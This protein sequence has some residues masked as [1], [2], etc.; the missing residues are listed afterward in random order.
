MN[1]GSW[2]R[3]GV[4]VAGVILLTAA[5]GAAAS[6]TVTVVESGTGTPL[7]KATVAVVS[8]DTVVATG[9]TNEQGVWNCT[10]PA[11]TAAA[12]ASK[13]LY[14]STGG[15]AISFDAD[16]NRQIRLELVKHDSADFK[17]LGRIVGFVRNAGGQPIGNATLVLQKGPGPVGAAQPENATGVYELEWYPPGT[18]SVIATAPGHK[19]MK[20]TG[21]TITAGESLWLDVT[22]PPR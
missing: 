4:T 13:K 3:K 8:G 5:V 21:Q 6:L 17:R 22:L 16:G 14:R 1:H 11:G 15:A 7:A 20:Y 2:L 19:T 12:V 9:R 18:Y 10:V